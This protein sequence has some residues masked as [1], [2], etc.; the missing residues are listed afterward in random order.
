[1]R[2]SPARFGAAVTGAL[3]AFVVLSAR[4]ASACSCIQPPSPAVALENSD[5]VFT[6]RI[7]RVA[8]KGYE[9]QV[10]MRVERTWKG[11]KAGA[12]VTV[13][14]G[15]GGGDCGVPFKA[16]TT[17]LVYAGQHEGTL[18]ASICSRTALLADA[19]E[20]IPALTEAA[21]GGS[22][23]KDA[24]AAPPAAAPAPASE[25]AGA[26]PEAT[27]TDAG[28]PA[29]ANPPPPQRP[30]TKGCA[31]TSGTSSEGGALPLAVAVAAVLV[32][33]RKK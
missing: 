6:A 14:T 26:I 21:R 27:T 31:A 16:G 30:S 15:M 8:T 11:S 4:D 22:S 5:A 3:L 7:E 13:L 18:R 32:R 28:A 1:M 20:D 23:T 12:S 33:R 2:R 19:K 24:G 25:D 9:K 29:F 17:W 10:V